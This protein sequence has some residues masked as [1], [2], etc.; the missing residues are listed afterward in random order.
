MIMRKRI[1]I[2]LC[3][4]LLGVV[5]LA[6]VLAWAVGAQGPQPGLSFQHVDTFGEMSVPYTSTTTH[7]NVPYALAVDGDDNVYVAERGGNRVLK[8]KPDGTF[9]LQIGIAGVS[10]WCLGE[11]SEGL[12]LGAPSGLAVDSSDNIWVAERGISRVSIFEPDGTYTGQLGVTGERGSDNEH[13]NRPEGVAFDSAGRI[14]VAD[15]NNNRVQI[16]DYFT[17]AYSATIGGTCGPGDYQ[18]CR[19]HGLAIGS[20][21]VLYVADTMN[22]RV[23]VYQLVGDSMVFSQSITLTGT[24]EDQ[25]VPGVAVDANY[26]YVI[27]GGWDNRV[28]VF[29]RSGVYSSTID[30]HCW[31]EDPWFCSP[32]DVAVDSEGNVYVADPQDIFRVMKCNGGPTWTCTSFA[33]TQGVPYLTDDRHFN[34]PTGV[35]V[36]GDSLFVAEDS[37]HRLLKLDTSGEPQ[38][39]AG[40]AGVVGSGNTHFDEPSAVAADSN[41][42]SYVADMFNH[43]VQIFNSD[44]SYYTTLGDG[45]CNPDDGIGHEEFCEPQGVAISPSDAIY[46]ADTENH[47][48]QIFNSDGSYYTTLGTPGEPGDDND[49]F[50]GPV[51]V[52]VDSSGNIYVA[53]TGNRRV[54]IFDSNLAYKMTLGPTGDGYF[55]GE[56]WDVAVDDNSGRIYVGDHWGFILVFDSN[57]D[58]LTRIWGAGGESVD[59]DSAGNIYANADCHCIQKFAPDSDGDGSPDSV[60]GDAPNGGDGNGDGTLDSQQANVASLPNAVDG[61]YVTLASPEGTSFAEVCAVENPSPEDSPPGVD[62]PVGFF[63]FTLQGIAQGGA[64]TVS[65]FLPPDVTLDTYY[66]YGP[67]PDSPTN[68][69]YEFL[70]YEA[71]GAEIFPD[72]VVLHFVDGQRGDDDLTTNGEIVEPGGPGDVLNR[73][74]EVV[75]GGPYE[76]DEGGSLA[77]TASGNDP[78]GDPLTYAWD[79]DDDGTFETPG[80]SV[81]FSAEG[82]DGPSSHTIA[83]QVTDSGGLSATDQTAVGVLNVAPT[84]GEITAPVAP[85]QV[86]TPINAGANFTDPG[87]LD[88][89]TAVWE[90]G[91]GSISQGTVEE[92]DGSGSVT[93]SHTY[94]T[95][96]V[97]TVKLTVTDDD[98]DSGESVFQYV[99]VYDPEGGFVTGGGWIDS[100]PGAFTADLDL[101]GRATFGFVAKYKKGAAEPTGETEFR[102]R[103]ADLNFHSDSYQ[104]LVIA[105]SKAQFKGTGTINGTG[106]YG[107]M[108]TAIDA[109]LTPSTEV[110]RFRIKIW[111]KATDVVIY[112]NQMDA[113]DDADPATALGGG[114]VVIH[115]GK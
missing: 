1:F 12:V 90:W 110:D 31:D 56:P 40:V 35:A 46:V 48:V 6:L 16:F 68:H 109:A 93:G 77:I 112:D 65:L 88:T 98:G 21:D 14:Y 45:D 99:V 47:R 36:V 11:G 17:R 113:D 85:V 24:T 15:T 111:D 41:Y 101:T 96:G 59:V 107:F 25:W 37:G 13:F 9:Q 43:R 83:V 26:V 49:H 80:Q 84:V 87:V 105:G 44:G 92:M 28:H 89:H 69:W 102:F 50:D 52:T 19:P 7:L 8:Y 2:A 86:E 3:G 97:Y 20:G 4:N 29:S 76:V 61:E 55:V 53:D 78:D 81:I 30:G 62:F 70:F 95:T 103:V 63:E 18:L 104:W 33:G 57:G 115:E 72:K 79:L 108:L 10:W 94:T 60:E 100:P 32:K 23:Q 114:S 38:W 66:K 74:P 73:P 64:T 91:D 58:Y 106:N 75:A 34:S 39:T 71:T 42:R 67:T 54:Q 82:L 27:E 51:G 22:A 5:A